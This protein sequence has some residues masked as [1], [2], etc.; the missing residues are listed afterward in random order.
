MH[1]YRLWDTRTHTMIYPH[2]ATESNVLYA[3][4]LHGLPIAI[5]LDPSDGEP[6]VDWSAGRHLIAMP[7]T[8]SRDKYG[9]EIYA[10][11]VLLLEGTTRGVVGYR[12][13]AYIVRCTTCH[14]HHIN[15][16]AIAPGLREVVGNVYE[17][18]TH[19]PKRDVDSSP[20]A[21]STRELDAI[22][23][24]ALQ[25]LRGMQAQLDE[26]QAPLTR[27]QIEAVSEQAIQRMKEKHIE[28]DWNE[29]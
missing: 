26:E 22:T 23:G 25:M 3:I 27:D 17:N 18:V 14:D 21:V 2:E 10:K 13:G 20:F 16:N 12:N 7:S 28:L 11:D 6:V 1:K 19:L 15:L 8:G 24:R 29:A 4:G 5:N 9:K